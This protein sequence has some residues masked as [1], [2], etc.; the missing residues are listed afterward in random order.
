MTFWKTLGSVVRQTGQALETAGLVLQRPYGYREQCERTVP[1]KQVCRGRLACG[2]CLMSW[3]FDTVP[4]HQTLQAFGSSRPS[5]GENCFVAPNAS[6]IG[7]VSLGKN[8]SVW[9]GAVLRGEHGEADMLPTPDG[10]VA[11]EECC[12]HPTLDQEPA[13]SGL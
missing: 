13:E 12:S 9:Y 7:D 3:L 11:F 4:R 6:L 10:V 2:S 8:T 5:L 1:L